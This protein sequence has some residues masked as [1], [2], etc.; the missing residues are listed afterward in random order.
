MCGWNGGASP[1]RDGENPLKAFEPKHQMKGVLHGTQP[2]AWDAGATPGL[3]GQALPVLRSMCAR[4]APTCPSDPTTAAVMIGELG[5]GNTTA[6][7]ALV[8]A[9]QQCA[10]ADAVGRGTGLDDAGV[11]HKAQ[12]AAPLGRNARAAHGAARGRVCGAIGAG[13]LVCARVLRGGREVWCVR[14][15]WRDGGWCT[16]LEGAGG[17]AVLKMSCAEL[18]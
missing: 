13:G 2:A 15:C 14:G 8:C 17:W 4:L 5:I 18:Q 12:V 11:A 3:V 10:P 9:L 1:V 16:V 7:S 6:S